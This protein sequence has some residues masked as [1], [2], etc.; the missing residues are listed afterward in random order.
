MEDINNQVSTTGMIEQKLLQPRLIIQAIA[1]TAILYFCSSQ[2]PPTSRGFISQSVQSSPPLSAEV[3]HS[4][5]RHA[6]QLSGLPTSALQ[7]V[8]AQPQTWS[9]NCL[10]LGE[11]GVSCI[12][13][14]IPGWQVAVASEQQRWIYRTN[15][16]GSIIKLERDISLPKKERQEVALVAY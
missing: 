4:V 7:V 1:F 3:S 10:G 6:S 5:L 11:A 13:T 9:D 2:T 14:P 16:S 12:Q 15:R 8:E